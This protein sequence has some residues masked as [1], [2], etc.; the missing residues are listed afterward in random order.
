MRGD[1]QVGEDRGAEVAVENLPAPLAE[2]DQ[3]RPVEAK[4]RPDARD[5]VRC[6]LVAGD[7]RGR[8]AG[9]DVEEAKHEQR[10]HRHHRD[11]G[12]DAADD[13]VQHEGMVAGFMPFC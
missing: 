4:A 10:N 13:V 7:H 3:E 5:I 11:G 8:I 1:R 12:E 6:R 9:R 2:P